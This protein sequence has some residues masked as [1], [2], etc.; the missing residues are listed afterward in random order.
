MSFRIRSDTVDDD[1]TA[2]AP[3]PSVAFAGPEAAASSGMAGSTDKI[4]RVEVSEANFERRSDGRNEAID[5]GRGGEGEEEEEEEG[6]EEGAW[7]V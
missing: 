4:G 5:K 6:E 1:T 3:K 2:T 7:S